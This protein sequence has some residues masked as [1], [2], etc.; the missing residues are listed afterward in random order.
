[1]TCLLNLQP[2]PPETGNSLSLPSA[3]TKHSILVLWLGQPHLFGRLPS[4]SLPAP[5][6]CLLQGEVGLPQDEAGNTALR[7]GKA[8]IIKEIRTPVGKC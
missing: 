8:Q 1:M 2:V 4:S 7:A 6:C 5:P 3:Q